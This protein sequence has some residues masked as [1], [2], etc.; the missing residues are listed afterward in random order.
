MKFFAIRLTI[1]FAKIEG[2]FLTYLEDNW[3]TVIVYEHVGTVTEKV[4]CHLLLVDEKGT[5]AKAIKVSKSFKAM[6]LIGNADLSFKTTFKCKATKKKYE[7]NLESC[8]K[9]I[10]YMSKGKIDPS[11]VSNCSLW[12]LKE[13]IKLMHEWED[14]PK[15]KTA[16]KVEAFQRYLGVERPPMPPDKIITDWEYHY[17]KKKVMHYVM[18]KYDGFDYGAQAEAKMLLVT[19]LYK[20][21]V[22]IPE[23]Q[24]S[25]L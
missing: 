16:E 14:K 4:H 15:S 9:Y 7:M 8:S 22:E 23:K 11:Y 10:T 20:W 2:E 1:P 12:N 5:E 18:E 24:K 21:R 17:L 25:Y 13:C 3:S 6:N 19:F